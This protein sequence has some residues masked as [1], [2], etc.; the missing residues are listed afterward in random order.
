MWTH[1]NYRDTKLKFW[2][3]PD[4]SFY[5]TPKGYLGWL[6]KV[7]K[8]AP[9]RMKGYRVSD[10]RMDNAIGEQ[11]RE[12]SDPSLVYINP[13]DVYTNENL[14]LQANKTFMARINKYN[15]LNKTKNQNIRGL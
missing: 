2:Q 4:E 3:P 6:D 8:I 5:R 9:D 15:N 1:G 10:L 13:G 14:I 12:N 7:N 11:Q